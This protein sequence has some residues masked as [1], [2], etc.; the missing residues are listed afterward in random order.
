[1]YFVYIIHSEKTGRY[2]AGSTNNLEDRLNRHNQSRNKYTKNSA[3]WTLTRYFECATRS[4]A[5]LLESK[6]KKRGIERFLKEM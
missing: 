2:Y 6:I 4:K 3:P 5:V 1:M